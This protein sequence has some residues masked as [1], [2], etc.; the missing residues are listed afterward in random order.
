[1]QKKSFSAD[2]HQVLIRDRAELRVRGSEFGV[3]RVKFGF[4]FGFGFGTLSSG[5]GGFGKPNFAE[6]FMFD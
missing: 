1:M 4:G 6:L 3:R 5:F 2:R